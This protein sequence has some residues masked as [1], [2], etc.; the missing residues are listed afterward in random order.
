MEAKGMTDINKSE[1]KKIVERGRSFNPRYYPGPIGYFENSKMTFCEKVVCG[2]ECYLSSSGCNCSGPCTDEE[3]KF[4]MEA[5]GMT[6]INKSEAK[7]IVE[8]G[9]SFNPRYYPGPIGYFE[10]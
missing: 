5:K 3:I 4:I 9:R 6:D 10:N 7:K 1:A 8:R 2:M